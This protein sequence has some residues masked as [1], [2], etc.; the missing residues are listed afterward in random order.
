LLD[1]RQTAP[2]HRHESLPVGAY[3]PLSLR[4]EPA[5]HP[6]EF[7]HSA[8]ALRLDRLVDLTQHER[9]VQVQYLLSRRG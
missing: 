7:F 2:H 9:G 1:V 6:H 5:H 8:A 4:G 3:S